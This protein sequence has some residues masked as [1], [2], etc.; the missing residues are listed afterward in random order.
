MQGR[1]TW[2]I[3]ISLFFIVIDIYAFQAVKTSTQNLTEVSRRI[4]YTVFY[5]ISFVTFGGIILFILIGPEN[6]PSVLRNIFVSFVFAMFLGKL[7]I[8]IFLLIDDL[9]R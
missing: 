3:I 6:I 4:W 9:I 1:L 5:S 7:L 8:S 2:I